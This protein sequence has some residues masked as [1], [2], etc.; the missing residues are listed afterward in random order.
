ML[1]AL[2]LGSQPR[3]ELRGEVSKPSVTQST[4]NRGSDATSLCGLGPQGHKVHVNHVL[5]YTHTY[6]NF[7]TKAEIEKIIRG[8]TFSLGPISNILNFQ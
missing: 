3:R 1:C 2:G 5:R 6:A 4:S 7:L 8:K